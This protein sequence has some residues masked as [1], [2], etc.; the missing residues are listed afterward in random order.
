MEAHGGRYRGVR[1]ELHVDRARIKTMRRQ[2]IPLSR[3]L[4]HS[5]SLR[6][7]YATR[8]G[9]RNV[10]SLPHYRNS[11]RSVYRQ[12]LGLPDRN[13]V[14]GQSRN[15]RTQSRKCLRA[16]GLFVIRIFWMRCSNIE[17]IYRA[18]VSYDDPVLVAAGPRPRPI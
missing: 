17:S 9:S 16:F 14:T 12:K 4:R 10:P 8:A 18:C 2:E 3:I 5:V 15:S 1:M 6:S 11:S 13:M 7:P